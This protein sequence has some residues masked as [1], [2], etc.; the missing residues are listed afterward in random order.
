[1]PTPIKAEPETKCKS[2]LPAVTLVKF[3]VEYAM[4]CK[5]A[6]PVASLDAQ[7]ASS[8]TP[9]K[10]VVPAAYTFFALNVP[11]EELMPPE[12]PIIVSL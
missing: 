11:A 3:A 9:P 12:P 8:V 7:V 10:A 6:V 1:M 4:F 2:S 5:P